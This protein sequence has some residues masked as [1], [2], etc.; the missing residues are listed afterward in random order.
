[1]A[2]SK[3]N[4]RTCGGHQVRRPRSAGDSRM[5]QDGCSDMGNTVAKVVC[6]QDDATFSLDMFLRTH[7]TYKH[8]RLGWERPV[9]ISLVLAPPLPAP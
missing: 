3:Y 2:W 4:G 9:C 6:G 8:S 1:M 5:G 7:A